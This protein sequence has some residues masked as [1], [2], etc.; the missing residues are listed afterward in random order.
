MKLKTI[1]IVAATVLFSCIGI[2]A[3]SPAVSEAVNVPLSTVVNYGVGSYLVAFALLNLAAVVSPGFAKRISQKSMVA[4]YTVAL[5]NSDLVKNLWKNNKFLEFAVNEDKYVLGGSVVHRPVSGRRASYQTN[6]SVLPAQ[7]TH[8]SATDITYTLD[9]ITTDP[10]LITAKD[11][12]ELN[13]DMRMEVMEDHVNAIQEGVAENLL[14]RW[15][16]STGTVAAVA[17]Q[18]RTSGSSVLRSASAPGASGLRKRLT[19][20][21]MR[22]AALGMDNANIPEGERYAL[23]TPTLIKDLMEDPEINKYDYDSLQNIADNNIPRIAS[24][25]ILKRSTVLVY[26]NTGTPV[27]KAIGAATATDDNAAGILWQRNQVSRA[28]GTVRAFAETDKPEYYGDVMST[29]C[30]VGG[31]IVRAEGVVV[32]IESAA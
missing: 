22:A 14:H 23:L 32:I 19:L 5:F 2:M 21:D 10:E 16:S 24:F 29:L 8:R 20:A 11:F 7:I 27:L 17:T 3:L 28:K 9:E 25:N 31:R 18:V 1:M 30:R 13:Y 6:R 4:A 15:A 26:D 12:D